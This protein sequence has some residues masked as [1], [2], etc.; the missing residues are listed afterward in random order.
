M[1]VNKARDEPVDESKFP[2]KLFIIFPNLPSN[3]IFKL[4]CKFGYVKMPPLRNNKA[5][6]IRFGNVYYNNKK[7]AD[8]AIKNINGMDF[9]GFKA[10]V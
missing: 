4:F 2:F 6:N 3:K 8:Q 7:S 10:K 5:K 1:K 9:E